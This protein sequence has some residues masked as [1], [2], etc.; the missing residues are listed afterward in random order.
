MFQQFFFSISTLTF[1][2]L[3]SFGMVMKSPVP[4]WFFSLIQHFSNHLVLTLMLWW[5][6]LW[7]FGFHYFMLLFVCGTLYEYIFSRFIYQHIS[8]IF[9]SENQPFFKINL[10]L[11]TKSLTCSIKHRRF[12][13]DLHHPFP[14]SSLCKF[15]LKINMDY[16]FVLFFNPLFPIVSI[17][18]IIALV[19]A[20]VPEI[21]TVNICK[22]PLGSPMLAIEEAPADH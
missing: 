10:D 12:C 6:V 2:Y 17:R 21:Q 20:C 7:W 5:W 15:V 11:S 8:S 4:L 19:F 13:L 16:I 14:V 18:R 1:F 9:K 22:I 3:D